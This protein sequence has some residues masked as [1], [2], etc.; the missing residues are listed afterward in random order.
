MAH[1]ERITDVPEH[2]VP[3][4]RQRMEQRGASVAVHD[5]GGGLFTVEGAYPDTEAAVA[6]LGTAG[7][8]AA[9][10]ALAANGATPASAGAGPLTDTQARTAKAIV[11][12]FET[13]EVLGDY[14]RVTLIPGDTG[15][16]TYGRSQTTLG[17]GLLHDLL[18]RYVGNAGARFRERM[19]PFLTRTANRDLTLDDDDGFHNNLRAAA[20]DP[21]MR[22]TQDV[23]F[24]TAYWRPAL[25]DAADTRLTLP[26]SVAVVYDGRVHGSW[27]RLR[28]ETTAAHGRVQAL[29]E[30]AWV[31]A[32]IARRRQWLATHQR[33]DLRPTVYRMDAFQRLADQG[34]WGLALP[35]VV[36]DREISALTLASPPP[37]VY[38]GP[39]PGTRPLAVASPL[40]RG[41]DVRLLQ[42]ALSDAGH[43][44]KADGIF[45][46]SASDT[47]RQFQQAE[48]QP[49]SGAADPAQVAALAARVFAA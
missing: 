18:E 41:L 10:T 39:V 30:R 24:D 34:R 14:G 33:A 43:S 27:A 35:L 7:V 8:Q 31:A 11:N 42:L 1:I 48:G 23:F 3:T 38:E 13:G 25:E 46:Q 45:G 4:I 44:I 12:I 17:S 49:A 16:L 5:Q 15:H 37:R 29:G 9:A 20:D 6:G 19:R 22:E 47:L 32:Y 40:T 26:L 2:M 28:D 21:V 36:R